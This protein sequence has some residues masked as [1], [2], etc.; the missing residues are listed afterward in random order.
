M[1]DVKVGLSPERLRQLY[2]LSL[3][4]AGALKNFKRECTAQ[5]WSVIELFKTDHKAE[6]RSLQDALKTKVSFLEYYS[7]CI[8]TRSFSQLKKAEK[9][10]EKKDKELKELIEKQRCAVEND[11]RLTQFKN[12]YPVNILATMVG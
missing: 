5:E 9:A 8:L 12:L 6:K 4:N 11:E 10:I 7:P 3:L 2:H 1:E